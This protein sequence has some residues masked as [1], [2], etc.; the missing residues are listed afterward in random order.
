MIRQLQKDLIEL[1]Y[2]DIVGSLDGINGANTKK[3]VKT[4]QKDIGYLDVDGIV[5]EKTQLAIRRRKETAGTVG[6][7]N[8][9]INEFSSPDNHSLPKDGMH[10]QLLLSLEFLRWKLGGRPVKINSG[11]RTPAFNKQIGGYVK[12]NHMTGRAADIKVIGVHPAKVQE[13]GA[14]IFNGLGRYKN[15][16]HVDTDDKKLHFQGKY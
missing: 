12:S 15:F 11:Y 2:G 3:A 7:R 1:G 5:G 10:N 6:T 8:F 14:S 9:N 13:A 16:T 4:F